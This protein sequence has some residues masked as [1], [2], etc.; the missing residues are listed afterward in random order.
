MSETRPPPFPPGAPVGRYYTVEG[1]VRLSEGRM[2]HLVNDDRPE[3]TWRKCWACGS[4]STPRGS[5]SCGDCGAPI[6]VRRF[7]LASRWQGPYEP[8]EAAMAKGLVHPAFVNPVEVFRFEGQLCTVFPYRGE[9][10]LLDEPAP[11]TNQRILDVAQRVAGVLAFLASNGVRVGPLTRANL[12]VAPDYGLQ[13][14]DADIRE[15]RDGGLPQ[16]A[17]GE[18]L[19]SLAD[20]LAH[21]CHVEAAELSAFLFAVAGGAHATPFAF[22]RELEKR[23]DV[24]AGA[25]FVPRVGAMSDVGLSRQLNEDSWGWS[26]LSRDLRLYVVADGMGGHDGGEVASRLAVD[27]LCRVARETLPT[28]EPTPENLERLL[29]DAF[30]AANNTVKSQAE[31]GGNDMGTTLVAALIQGRERA[32][33]ANVGDSRAYV[34][35]DHVLHQVSTDHSLVQ[36]MVERGRLTPAEARHHPHSNILLRTVGT[37]RDID[38]DVDLVSLRAGDRLM[39]CSDG[40]WGEVEDRDL[41]S[42]MDTYSDPRIASRE[43]VR[44]SHHGGGKDNVTL[45]LV[46]LV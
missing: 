46:D 14:F 16:E 15:V 27:T 25:T 17:C 3:H 13:L 6:Q 23:F 18:A 41:E 4:E 34:M 37:E 35:R 44:A 43:M 32:W 2:F 10:L 24:Y 39:M 33:V 45:V 7:V 28:I 38:I 22:G 5:A 19:K 11:L 26:Q 31:S 8:V 21:Y 1:L 40:L 9:R 12:L 36:K 20:L 42:I 29:A 30:Q